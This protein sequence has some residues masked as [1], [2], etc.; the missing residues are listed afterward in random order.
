MT[1]KIA[2]SLPDETLAA[3]KRAVRFGKAPNV[4]NYVSSLINE[5]A[6]TESFEAMIADWIRESNASP[7]EVRVAE[8]SAL[9]DFKRAGLVGSLSER[10]RGTSSRK[11]G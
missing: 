4:S 5:H 2:I 9:R 8:A 10:N 1:K 3:A 7:S 11:T 6:A